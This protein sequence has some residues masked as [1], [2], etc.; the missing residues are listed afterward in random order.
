MSHP[1]NFSFRLNT[2]FS[3]IILTKQDHLLFWIIR[4][5]QIEVYDRI[6]KGGYIKDHKA[7]SV[8]LNYINIV[9]LFTLADKML[10]DRQNVNV[11]FCFSSFF[12]DTCN[13]LVKCLFLYVVCV[14][15]VMLTREQCQ[16]VLI[17]N[18]ASLEFSAMIF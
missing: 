6:N 13:T 4:L 10:S 11:S 17:R 5:I 3:L 1:A 12:I 8:V 14:C 7:S 15:L 16:L 18:T 9:M 2:L